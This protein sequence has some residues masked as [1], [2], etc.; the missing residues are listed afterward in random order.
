MARPIDWHGSFGSAATQVKNFGYSKDSSRV[1]SDG[2]QVINRSTGGSHDVSLQ[3]YILKLQPSL[4]I[5]DSA[6]FS[7][8][9]STGYGYGGQYG[10]NS[11]QNNNGNFSQAL[12][13]YNTSASTSNVS[14]RK[15]YVELFSDTGTFVIGRQTSHWGLGAVIDSGSDLWDRHATIRDGLSIKYKVGNF[16]IT[17]YYFKIDSTGGFSKSERAKEYGASLLYDNSER[18]MK[19]GILAGK[20]VSD[21][22]NSFYNTQINTTGTRALNGTEVKVIDLYLDKT[23]GRFNFAVEAPI[24]SGNL[25]PVYNVGEDTKF[26]AN[27]ILAKTNYKLSDTFSF[28]LNGGLVGGDDGKTGT[29]KAMYLHPNF[30]IANLM[31][32]Y[33]FKAVAS[34]TTQN[35]YDQYVTNIKY[36]KLHAAYSKEKWLWEGAIIKAFAR[37]VAKNG[38]EFFNHQTNEKFSN[39]V[40]DQDDDY[41]LEV[42]INFTYKWNQNVNIGGE[43]GYWSV[44]N[45]FEYTNTNEKQKLTD[46]YSY[47]LNTIVFF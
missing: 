14:L 10:Q 41:G 46:T 44:G 3:D 21:A 31:F 35:L 16:N 37:E 28:G 12:Y 32:R 9:L 8:E 29:F 40:G 43:I 34:P 47:A 33:N 26:K 24:Y 20:K 25:G 23:F 6:T 4:I 42:D 7:G 5:N 27:A 15:F 13:Y 11:T 39:A 1:E 2:S 38:Q 22:F 30:N 45:Y 17:P 18:E 19:F 36:L